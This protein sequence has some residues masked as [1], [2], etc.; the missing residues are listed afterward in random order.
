MII[1]HGNNFITARKQSL[2]QGTVFTR[3]CLFSN[4][5]S[6]YDVTSCLTAWS[7]VPSG[8]GVCARSHVP[9]WMWV[10]VWKGDLLS[11][12]SLSRGSLETGGNPPG[13]LFAQM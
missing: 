13:R 5:G 11:G 6:L 7:H 9:V 8:R 10:S 2:G 3:V 1:P 4:A 12:G